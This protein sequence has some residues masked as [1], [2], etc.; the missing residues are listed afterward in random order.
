M[1][2]YTLLRVINSTGKKIA[3]QHP[4]IAD[5]YKRGICMNAIVA[6]AGIMKEYKITSKEVARN[7][8]AKA[9]DY[10]IKN[11]EE[12]RKF[13][14]EIQASASTKVGDAHYKNGTGIYR[15][16]QKDK[17]KRDKKA[18]RSKGGRVFNWKEKVLLQS[19][20]RSGKYSYSSLVSGREQE[21]I[22][23]KGVQSFMRGMGYFRT[24]PSL[25][26]HYKLN[27]S[28]YK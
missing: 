3:K 11:K 27:I 4:E 21:N 9:L 19:I 16:S 6:E 13:G 28:Y 2:N 8:V 1:K 7:C 12:R 10:L 17:E 25:R 15:L 23:W 20:L 18:A 24:I 5:Y 26:G 14:L 22:D